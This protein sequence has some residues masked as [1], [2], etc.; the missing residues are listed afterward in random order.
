VTLS[1]YRIAG[2]REGYRTGRISPVEIAK[3]SLQRI[4]GYGD[5]A[6]FIARCPEAQV[7]ARAAGL[8]AMRGNIES[9]PLYGIP[10][11]VKDNIDAAG[12]PTTAG[13]P[14]FAYSPPADSHVVAR[15]LAAGAILMG[16]TNLDQFATGLVG[17]RSPYGAPRCVFD[18][19]Y[20]SG[21]SSSGSAVAVAAGLVAFSLG[22]DTAGSGRVPAAYNNIV[23]LKPTR[24]LIGTKGVV[25]ACRSLDCVSIFAQ[26]VAD[27]EWVL[28]VAQGFDSAD[29]YS[30]ASRPRA[31]AL[32]RLRVGVLAREEQEFFGDGS[33]AQAYEAAIARLASLGGEPVR[34]DFT[35]FREAGNLLY[36]GAWT[37]ERLAAIKDFMAGHESAMDPSVRAIIAGAHNLS[38]ADAFEGQYRLAEYARAAEAQWARMDV[39]LLPTVPTQDTVEDV[40]ADPIARNARLG[41][42]T[43]FVNLLDCCAIALPAGFRANGLP[44]GITLIAPAFC[45][46]ALA[47]L[48]DAFERGRDLRSLEPAA[49][50]P[51]IPLFVVGAHLKGMPLNRELAAL[52][53]V[54]ARE[55]RTAAHYRFFVLPHTTPKKPGLIAS[56]GSKGGNIAG[57]VWRLPPGAF[58]QFAAAIPAPL[59]I[60]KIALED[61]SEISGFL[62]EAYA[63]E[64]ATEI[65]HFGGWRNYLAS[66]G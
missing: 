26:D 44:F 45:D 10:F 31:L 59:G 14:E 2:L 5:K 65:T 62:C 56:P 7:M 32:N 40:N 15:L 37:A 18:S 46:D 19:R 61:G 1:P 60:G 52:G 47:T 49:K 9:L 42:Y 6:V 12:L 22:T 21:G 3:E 36:G 25:P 53:A 33:S 54:F 4:A 28:R 64:G 13:C 55:A 27:A 23:G 35:P 66:L 24:G 17:T 48:A 29:P 16:K 8:E 39:L 38:A 57:E 30:R 20:V 41:R 63:I 43:N 34:I 11:A 51:L 50:E 58:G